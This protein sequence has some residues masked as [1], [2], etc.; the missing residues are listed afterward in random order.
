[1]TDTSTIDIVFTD[2]KPGRHKWPKQG[3]DG[4]KHTLS[5]ESKDGC[6]RFEKTCKVCGM[7]RITMIPPRGYAWHKW[8]PKGGDVAFEMESTPPC[9]GEGKA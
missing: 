8:K 5:H 6:E 1:M 9:V 7:T 3:E 2:P 4:F